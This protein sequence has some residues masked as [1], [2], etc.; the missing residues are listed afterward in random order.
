MAQ[1]NVSV[2]EISAYVRKSI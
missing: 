2:R 1:T